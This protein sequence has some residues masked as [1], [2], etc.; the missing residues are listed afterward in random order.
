MTKELDLRHIHLGSTN[1][2]TSQVKAPVLKAARERGLTIYRAFNRF[3]LF[4]VAGQPSGEGF[5]LLTKDGSTVLLAERA[6]A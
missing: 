5:S 6:P 1:L 2:L 3:S 4:W